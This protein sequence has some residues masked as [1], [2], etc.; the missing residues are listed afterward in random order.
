MKTE[1]IYCTYTTKH[2]LQ[3]F[4]NANKIE[5]NILGTMGVWQVIFQ[6]KSFKIYI[7]ADRGF[8]GFQV[9]SKDGTNLALKSNNP[10]IFGDFFRESEGNIDL[11]IDFLH[12]NRNEIFIE[13]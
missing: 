13:E 4:Q 9:L 8:L 10:E 11:I 12:E 7:S 3:K 2:F 5:E 1:E 6:I